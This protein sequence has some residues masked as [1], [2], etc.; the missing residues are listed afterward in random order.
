MRGYPKHIATK[1]D[2]INLLTTDEFRQQALRDLI[3]IAK[4]QDDKATVVVSGSEETG[5]LVTKEIPNPMPLW[6][7]KGFDSKEDLIKLIELAKQIV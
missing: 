5:D 1:Q 7:I 2:F 4:V 3:R 6:K